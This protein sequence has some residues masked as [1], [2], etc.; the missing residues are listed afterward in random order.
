MLKLQTKTPLYI[1]AAAFVLILAGRLAWS[2]FMPPMIFNYTHSEPYGFYVLN[3]HKADEYRRGMTVIFPVPKPFETM[4]FGRD[5][6]N[7]GTPLMKQIWGLPGDTVCITDTQATVNGKYL[8]PVSRFDSMGR[9]LPILRGCFTIP[10]GYFFPAGNYI[11]NSFDGRY[12]GPVPLTDIQ[13][14]ARPKWTF[15][16]YY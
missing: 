6:I 1:M 15:S 10:A 8:G 14:E 3:V 11:P 9:E 7:R 16:L 2:A 5:W 4:V 12:I 13:A